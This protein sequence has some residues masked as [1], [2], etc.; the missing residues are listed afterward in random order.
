M[1]FLY[2]LDLHEI[3]ILI[4]EHL[5]RSDILSCTKVSKTFYASFL[6]FLWRKVVVT[7]E[8]PSFSQAQHLL[9][10]IHH[11]ELQSSP[12]SSSV[13]TRGFIHLTTFKISGLDNPKNHH[14]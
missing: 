4:A 11:L 2:A 7:Q 13:P 12:T 14:D 9:H 8:G 10:K 1:T 5:D 3:L 6:P